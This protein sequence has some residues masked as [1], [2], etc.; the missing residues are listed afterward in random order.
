MMFI[1]GD[2]PEAAARMEW[3]INRQVKMLA[4]FPTLG[5]NGRLAETLELV[6]NRTQFIL[7][8]RVRR[9]RIEILRLLHGAEK[10][11]LVI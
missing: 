6:V 7:I 1:A 8:F 10:W 9:G 2:N 4:E 11:P 5:R 3:E